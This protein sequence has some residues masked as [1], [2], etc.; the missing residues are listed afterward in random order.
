MKTSMVFIAL[1]AALI[2]ATAA[3]AGGPRNV[4]Y[5]YAGQ[6]TAAPGASSL[7]LSVAD[8]NRRALRSLLGQSDQQT[9]TFDS[10]TEFL[11]WHAGVPTVVAPSTL[12]AGDWVRVNVRANPGASLS[13]IEATPPGIVGDHVT[14][15]QKPDR[16]LYLFRG[17][18]TSV[19]S[20]TVSL[21]VSG[22]NRHA[23]RL[24]IGQPAAQTFDFD[25]TTII[26]LWQ[27]KVPTV[28]GPSQLKI[29]DRFVVRVRADKGASLAQVEE[30]AA[31]HLGDREPASAEPAQ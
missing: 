12:A 24:L 4:L 14:M 22:G 25:S 10:S 18:L 13:E 15:P 20:S 29:G 19:G 23:L 31:A 3:A 26:L 27:G 11:E 21:D 5:S 1:A 28:I 6:L 30:T 8:G 2:L 9:F 7:E 16:P 17:T